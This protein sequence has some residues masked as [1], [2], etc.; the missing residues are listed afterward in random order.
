MVIVVDQDEI[1]DRNEHRCFE[2]ENV[3]FSVKNVF[4]FL[5]F[6]VRLKSHL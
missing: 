5:L 6:I 4:S 1:C 2:E 3:G